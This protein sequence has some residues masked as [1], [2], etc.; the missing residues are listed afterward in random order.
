MISVVAGFFMAKLDV[1]SGHAVGKEGKMEMLPPIF[2][3]MYLR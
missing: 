2:M 1:C 3:V